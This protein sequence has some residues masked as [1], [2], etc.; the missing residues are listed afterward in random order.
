MPA[1]AMLPGS[2]DDMDEEPNL[3]ARDALQFEQREVEHAQEEQVDLK[4]KTKKKQ[5]T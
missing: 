3:V 5:K 2:I 4:K 1:E